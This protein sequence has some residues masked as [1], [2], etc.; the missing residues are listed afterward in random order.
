MDFFFPH[1]RHGDIL[2]CLKLNPHGTLGSAQADRIRRGMSMLC[3]RFFGGTTIPVGHGSFRHSVEEKL[4]LEKTS[5][6]KKKV[7]CG[8]RLI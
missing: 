1:R 7:P 3:F 4:V 6:T 5:R 2:R 8:M